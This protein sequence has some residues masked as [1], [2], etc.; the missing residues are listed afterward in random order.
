VID[1]YPILDSAGGD[2]ETCLWL[3]HFDKNQHWRD[4]GFIVDFIVASITIR[5][6][7]LLL[8]VGGASSQNGKSYEVMLN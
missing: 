1:D 5:I 3:N 7:N 8:P 6:G 2:Q 4:V